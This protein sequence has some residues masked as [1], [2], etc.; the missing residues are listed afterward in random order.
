M[1]LVKQ[2]KVPPS[3]GPCYSQRKGLSWLQACLHGALV[4]G[5]GNEGLGGHPIG[6]EPHC[7]V[8][9][10]NRELAIG[11]AMLST[12]DL[13]STLGLPISVLC[14]VGSVHK[15]SGVH[16]WAVSKSSTGAQT[17]LGD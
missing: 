10:A 3:T 4:L 17:G 11:N 12:K 14:K 5:D 8:R 6:R 7:P 15:H 16:L 13:Y 9:S 1:T 2:S